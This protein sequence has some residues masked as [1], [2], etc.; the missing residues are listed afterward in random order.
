MQTYLPYRLSAPEAMPPFLGMQSKY[1]VEGITMM[2]LP[3]VSF[4]LTK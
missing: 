1:L 2:H 3:W 4:V